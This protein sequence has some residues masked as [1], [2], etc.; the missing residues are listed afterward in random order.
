M[1][2][3]TFEISTD[4]YPYR[5]YHILSRLTLQCYK[6]VYIITQYKYYVLFITDLISGAYRSTFLL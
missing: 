4:L 3:I 5:L 6:Y 1:Y 2:N